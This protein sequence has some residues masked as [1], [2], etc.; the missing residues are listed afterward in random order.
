MKKREKELWFYYVDEEEFK[1]RKKYVFGLVQKWWLNYAREK[2]DFFRDLVDR[3]TQKILKDKKYS[4]WVYRGKEVSHFCDVKLGRKIDVLVELPDKS[5]LWIECKNQTKLVTMKTEISKYASDVDEVKK[6]LPNRTFRRAI[7]CSSMSRQDRNHCL[8]GNFIYPVTLGKIYLPNNEH[9]DDYDECVKE[10]E[11]ELIAEQID[12]NVDPP[13]IEKGL[14]THLFEKLYKAL[15]PRKHWA[16][17]L[18]PIQPRKRKKQP[19][20][21][22]KATKTVP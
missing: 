13:E 7:V 19:K 5:L 22:V 1:R 12:V 11:L 20:Q 17:G 4:K 16:Y 21:K 9:K 6:K 14:R 2:G 18:K 15:Q 8:K 10:W 3:A